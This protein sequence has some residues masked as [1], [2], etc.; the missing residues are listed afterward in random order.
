MSQMRKDVFSGEWVIFASNRKNKPYNYKRSSG[1][2]EKEDNICPFCPEN[3]NMT[4]PAVFELKNSN[5]WEIRV[6]D[7]MYPALNGE[8]FEKDSD[9]F[10]ESFNGFGIHEVIVDTPKHTMDIANA[11]EEHLYRLLCVINQRLNKVLSH[12]MIEYVQVFK[13][14]GPYAGAS[15]SHS[16][17]QVL[18]VPVL[19]SE[20]EA[21]FNVFEKHKAETGRCI[22][23]DMIKH[24]KE[25]KKRIVN[26]NEFFV[27]FTPYASRQS[28]EMWIVPKRHIQT[29]GDLS[30]D[31]LKSLAG[32]LKDMLIRIESIRKDISFNICI[33]EKAKS[34]KDGLFHWYI[35]LLPRIGSWA[36]FE[37]ATRCF[38]NP[39]L[40]EYSAEFYRKA[41]N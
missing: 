24:E 8:E 2:E 15:I 29:M 36:G 21:A 27:S 41:I 35:R 28:F 7:N 38:I 30:D 3:E 10:Y 16:H 5:G 12:E 23:C 4:P 32:F 11:S 22:M 14:N 26:E 33:Q 9:S 19:T 17:W 37:Y 31:E 13:N 40:P 34:T 1:I 18:G 39:I 6:F 20:Q 25:A